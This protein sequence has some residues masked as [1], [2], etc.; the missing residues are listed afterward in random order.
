MERKE[1]IEYYEK[2][3]EKLEKHKTEL[4]E[5]DKST[6]YTD[7]KISHIYDLLT[8]LKA[9]QKSEILRIQNMEYRKIMYKIEK[10]LEEVEKAKQRNNNKE[11]KVII[12]KLLEYLKEK[13]EG[14][15]NKKDV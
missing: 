14:E 5:V 1:I 11:V 12:Y 2:E 10:C 8:I 15:T 7:K 13:I 3:K 9:C 4:L 6:R